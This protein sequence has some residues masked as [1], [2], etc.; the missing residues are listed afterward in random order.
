MV[1]DQ[2]EQPCVP[3]PHLLCPTRR[4]T[5]LRGGG[6]LLR[7]GSQCLSLGAVPMAL[8]T[9]VDGIVLLL[10][11]SAEA[12]R[13]AAVVLWWINAA[14]SVLVSLGAPLAMFTIQVRQGP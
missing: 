1:E 7:T 11:T 3:A 2:L 6:S 12:A 13:T 8:A 14:L 9:I 4:V 5:W 10:P